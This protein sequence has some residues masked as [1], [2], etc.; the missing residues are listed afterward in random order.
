MIM[1][2]V[3]DLGRA[4]TQPYFEIPKYKSGCSK[5]KTDKNNIQLGHYE[6]GYFKVFNGYV[7][8]L[9]TLL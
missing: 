3:C 8:N 1:K 6:Q 4:G 5:L 7:S 9:L 2:I